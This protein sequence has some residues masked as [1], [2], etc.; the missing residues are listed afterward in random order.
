MSKIIA[1]SGSTKTDWAFLDN[2]IMTAHVQTQGIN[3]FHQQEDEIAA[4]LRDELLPQLSSLPSEV[5]FYGSGVRPELEPLMCSMLSDAFPGAQHIEAH[6]DLLGAAIAV[7]GKDAGVA[8]ILGTGANSCLYDGKRIVLNT[9][10][11]GYILGDEGSGAV[12]GIHFLNALL[13][14]RLSKELRDAFFDSMQMTEGDVIARVYRQPMANRW[15][16]SLSPFIHEHISAP[17]VRDIVIDNFRSFFYRNVMPYDR[18]DLPV[19]AVGSIAFFF[20]S[21]FREA[22]NYYDFTVGTILRS[23]LEGLLRFNNKMNDDIR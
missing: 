11:L 14:G 20:Q 2:G 7:C 10:P 18:R 13:K 3:P 19:G 1:D 6:G 8:C 22:A 12:M 16:A 21:E 15:L 17:G 4:I 5:Y 9:P 23:P